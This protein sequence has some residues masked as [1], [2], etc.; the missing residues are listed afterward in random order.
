[1]QDHCFL[2]GLVLATV[3]RAGGRGSGTDLSRLPWALWLLAG[4]PGAAELTPGLVTLR[5]PFITC[6]VP[7][8]SLC[9]PTL[10][11]PGSTKG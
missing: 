11:P 8:Q 9:P 3:A 10:C 7:A 6:L 4:A 2:Q 1:M 5:A